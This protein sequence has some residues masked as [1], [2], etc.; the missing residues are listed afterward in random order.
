LARLRS[1]RSADTRGQSEAR[2]LELERELDRCRHSLRRHAELEVRAID[3]GWE[4]RARG[5]DKG[6][7]VEAI[8]ARLGGQA[9]AVYAGDDETD[10]DAFA[11]VSRFGFG[12]RVGTGDRST[13]AHA[14]LPDVAAMAAFLE[15]WAVRF[16]GATP[17]GAAR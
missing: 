10:E 15:I 13:R 17:L 5:R 16:A 4:L 3:G 8:G 11:A 1:R 9:F 7:A 14:R 6:T 2:I 12:V